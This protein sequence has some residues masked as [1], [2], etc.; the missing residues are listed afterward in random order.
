MQ[1]ALNA[2]WG[3]QSDFTKSMFVEKVKTRDVEIQYEIPLEEIEKQ[4]AFVQS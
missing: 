3:G 1:E 4:K 2:P